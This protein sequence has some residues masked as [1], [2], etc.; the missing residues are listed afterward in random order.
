MYR[1]IFTLVASS[2]F[3]SGCVVKE[4]PYHHDRVVVE[5][6]AE[7]EVRDHYRPHHEYVEEK[8]EY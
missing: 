6:E 8:V 7:V 1:S 4:E 5:P 2:I 3:C